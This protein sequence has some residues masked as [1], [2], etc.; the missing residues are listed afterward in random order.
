MQLTQIEREA[1]HADGKRRIDLHRRKTRGQSSG[2]IVL[3][4]VN[5]H[6]INAFGLNL[7]PRGKRLRDDHSDSVAQSRNARRP[8]TAIT[9]TVANAAINKDANAA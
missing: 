8:L 6:R 4:L 1:R 7:P 2:L 5:L 3:P 9:S